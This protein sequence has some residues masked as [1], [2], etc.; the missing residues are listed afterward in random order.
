MIDL[1]SALTG[2]VVI[3]LTM[4]TVL[5]GRWLLDPAPANGRARGVGEA[6]L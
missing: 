1:L 6:D 5:L 3:G 4:A 2:V